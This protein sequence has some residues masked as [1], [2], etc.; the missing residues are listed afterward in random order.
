MEMGVKRIR[1]QGMYPNADHDLM[2]LGM[3]T[4]MARLWSSDRAGIPG[5]GLDRHGIKS[6]AD[7]TRQCDMA[8][9]DAKRRIQRDVVPM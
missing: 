3:I 2:K 5:E 7:P 9:V 8:S 1:F 4:S 6:G